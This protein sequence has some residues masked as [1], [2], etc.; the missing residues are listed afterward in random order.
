M[1]SKCGKWKL[2][3]SQFS[4]LVSVVAAFKGIYYLCDFFIRDFKISC[5]WSHHG[6]LILI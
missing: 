5:I 1:N 2:V 4:Q 6:K 3:K